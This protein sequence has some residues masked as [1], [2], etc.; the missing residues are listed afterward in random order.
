[1][2]TQRFWTLAHHQI[3]KASGQ[4]NLC[5]SGDFSS[6]GRKKRDSNLSLPSLQKVGVYSLGHPEQEKP[7]PNA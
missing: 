2:K 6:W 7:F 3:L 1:M 4:Q 5:V